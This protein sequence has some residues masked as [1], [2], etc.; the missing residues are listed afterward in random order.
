MRGYITAKEAAVT[1]GIPYPTMMA[2]I[3]RR[4]WL[5]VETFGRTIMIKKSELKKR[6]PNASR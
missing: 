5:K 2:R 6:L 3:R 1:L 4:K